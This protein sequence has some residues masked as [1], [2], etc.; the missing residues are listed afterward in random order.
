[1]YI[2]V[3]RCDRRRLRLEAQASHK[4]IAYG[5]LHRIAARE[6]RKSLSYAVSNDGDHAGES[7]HCSV[8]AEK[9]SSRNEQARTF[10]KKVEGGRFLLSSNTSRR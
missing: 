10:L 9:V 2:E 5:L 3:A 8:A 4:L 1:M 7:L 6:G